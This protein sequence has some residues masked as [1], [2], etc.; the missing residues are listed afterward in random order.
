MQWALILMLW[1]GSVDGGVTVTEIAF[2][3]EASCQAA[4]KEIL[5]AYPPHFSLRVRAVCVRKT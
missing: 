2:Q 1:A 4:A 5:A 3:S